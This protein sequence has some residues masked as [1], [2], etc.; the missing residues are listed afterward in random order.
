MDLR[1]WVEIA[2]IGLIG[3]F[4]TWIKS[5]HSSMKKRLDEKDKDHASVATRLAVMEA[6]QKTDRHHIDL[7]FEVL[8]KRLDDLF[9]KFDEYERGRA[10]FL[11]K[12]EFK[13]RE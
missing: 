9:K 6:Q 8:N 13:K 10:E 1:E 2:L 5:E 11:E 7:Q 4:A 12:F 3:I